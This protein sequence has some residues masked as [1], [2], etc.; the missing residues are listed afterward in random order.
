M[1]GDL[2]PNK[3]LNSLFKNTA[4]IKIKLKLANIPH[5]IEVCFY[6]RLYRTVTDYFPLVVLPD[7]VDETIISNIGIGCL[8]TKH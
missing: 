1:P 6:Q 4:F 2:R 8:H 7:T 5:V 3:F